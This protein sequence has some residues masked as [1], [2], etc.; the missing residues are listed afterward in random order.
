[1]NWKRELKIFAWACLALLIMAPVAY[2]L[3]GALEIAGWLS[4]LA[5]AVLYYGLCLAAWVVASSI[6][7]RRTKVQETTK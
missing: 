4:S 2:V 7:G 1:M 6:A 5:A 3:S